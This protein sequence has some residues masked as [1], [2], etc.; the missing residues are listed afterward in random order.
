[1]AELF[2]SRTL[3]ALSQLSN[4]VRYYNNKLKISLLKYIIYSSPEYW[5]CFQ[6]KMNTQMK[7]N[8]TAHTWGNLMLKL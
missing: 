2:C 7:A 1:M 6:K 4:K 8:L 3:K 5:K